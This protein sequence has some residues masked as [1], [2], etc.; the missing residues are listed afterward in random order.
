[1]RLVSIVAPLFEPSVNV[2]NTVVDVMFVIVQMLG[3]SGGK[4]MKAPN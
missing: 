1:M 2:T 3:A 4:A